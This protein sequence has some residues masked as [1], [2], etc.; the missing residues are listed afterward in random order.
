MTVYEAIETMRY[1]TRKNKTFSFSFMSYSISKDESHG[2]VNV[3]RAKLSSRPPK[4]KNKYND[5]MLSAINEDTHQEFQ[6]WQP[7]LMF[8]EG[9]KVELS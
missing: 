2:I 7:L 1:M 9:Q 5:Y 4:E 8:F 3:N 6:F